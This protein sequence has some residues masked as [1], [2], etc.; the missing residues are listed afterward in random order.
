LRLK[1]W[2]GPSHRTFAGHYGLKAS[3]QL[4]GD[5]MSRELFPAH[6]SC[7]K[8]KMVANTAVALHRG[9]VNKFPGGRVSL[10]VVEHGK[11]LNEKVFRPICL[12]KVRGASNKGQM[13]K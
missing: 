7:K 8:T 6:Q 5:V 2:F 9:D 12:F 10:R 1:G 4:D 11:F 13:V 3:R